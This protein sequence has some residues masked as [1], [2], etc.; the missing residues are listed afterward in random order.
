VIGAIEHPLPLLALGAHVE[1]F[2][3][4]K[5]QGGL[6]PCV[7]GSSDNITVPLGRAKTKDMSQKFFHD[8]IFCHDEFH[9]DGILGGQL[10]SHSARK[11]AS[12]HNRK[13]GCSKEEKDL[14]GWW[15]KDEL[16]SDVHDDV[17]LPQGCKSC[18]QAVHWWT[19]QARGKGRWWCPRQFFALACRAKCADTA[20]CW[21]GKSSWQGTFMVD[22]FT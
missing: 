13:N 17:D 9:E 14:E 20:F 12:A 10:R 8:E 3:E 6:T 18:R 16:I 2:L 11:H 5:V 21:C 7:F 1:T 4:S 15:K 22:L 19:L